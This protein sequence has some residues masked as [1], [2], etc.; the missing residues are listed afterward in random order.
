MMDPLQGTE[1]DDQNINLTEPSPINGDLLC[2]G[3]A[4]AF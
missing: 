1:T 4:I 3:L 2:G